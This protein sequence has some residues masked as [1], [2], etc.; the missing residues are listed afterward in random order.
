MSV[1]NYKDKEEKKDLIIHIVTKEEK[2]KAK[3]R[4]AKERK[5]K[6]RKTKIEGIEPTCWFELLSNKNSRKIED[7]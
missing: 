6:E 1:N 3:E 5:A 7:F 4:K 2:A